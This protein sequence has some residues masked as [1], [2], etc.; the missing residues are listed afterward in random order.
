MFEVNIQDI[1]F[2]A[3]RGKLNEA[4]KISFYDQM[5]QIINVEI[6]KYQKEEPALVSWLTEQQRH[7]AKQ[8]LAENNI[9]S[10]LPL[11]DFFGKVEP[12]YPVVDVIFF[13]KLYP[14]SE[15]STLSGLN[16]DK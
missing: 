9:P 11:N 12:N 5:Y 16:A 2:K 10:I 8:E 13:Q 1:D 7:E 6:R 15:S 3:K 4:S 14:A